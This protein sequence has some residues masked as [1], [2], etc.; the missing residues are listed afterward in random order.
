MLRKIKESRTVN[1]AIMFSVFMLLA[2][3]PASA[4]Q[5]QLVTGATKLG[6]DLFTWLLVLIP[7]YAIVMFAWHAWMK[8]MAE[9]EGAE[10]AARNKSMKR[11]IIFSAIAEGA[12][13]L[14]KLLLAYFV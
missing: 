11:V 12:S 1:L 13:G 9:G 4:S 2:A 14:V 7:V 8:S 3:T 5:P 6:G 10:V